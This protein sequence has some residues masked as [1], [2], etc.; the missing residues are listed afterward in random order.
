MKEI[1]QKKRKPFLMFIM[2]ILVIVVLLA[3]I[4][5]IDNS[6]LTG[7]VTGEMYNESEPSNKLEDSSSQDLESSLNSLIKENQTE[8]KKENDFKNTDE[9]ILHILLLKKASEEKDIIRTAEHYNLLN[10]NMI[11]F[12][13]SLNNWRD[14]ASCV[15]TRCEDKE[16]IDLIDSLSKNNPSQKNQIIQ[17]LIET[18]KLWT[19]HNQDLFSKSL[20]KTNNL[21]LEQ[22]KRVQE[23]WKEMIECNGCNESSKLIFEIIEEIIRE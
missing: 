4:F 23:L 17:S 3:F 8:L 14:V 15:Y 13:D 18:Y 6:R 10:E 7:K 11:A 5:L 22:D 21:M 1:K 20:V 16:Y 2:V 9:L 12:D 19:G